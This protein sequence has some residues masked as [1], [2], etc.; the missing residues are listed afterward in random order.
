MF[1]Q[2]SGCKYVWTLSDRRLDVSRGVA[3]RGGSWTLPD[4]LWVA[5][6]LESLVAELDISLPPSLRRLLSSGFWLQCVQQT[7]PRRVRSLRRRYL[8]LYLSFT[9]FPGLSAGR[10]PVPACFGFS[11]A[12]AERPSYIS[13]DTAASH[14][15]H[16]FSCLPHSVVPSEDS[17]A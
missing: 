7:R 17:A 14:N 3:S 2:F 10:D 12:V 6:S 13:Y 11:H 15:E 8:F 5:F 16:S 4:A 9:A 1:C